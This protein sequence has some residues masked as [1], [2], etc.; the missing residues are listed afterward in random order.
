MAKSKPNRQPKPKRARKPSTPPATKSRGRSP[1]TLAERLISVGLVGV[2]ALA[3]GLHTFDSKMVSQADPSSPALAVPSRQADAETAISEGSS[4]P[5]GGR[6]KPIRAPVLGQA[7]D[8]ATTQLIKDGLK[9]ALD[10]FPK[11]KGTGVALI[12]PSGRVVTGINE[13]VPMMPA[14]TIK[15]AT[16]AALWNT[17]GPDHQ[18]QTKIMVRGDVSGDGVVQ[19]D[20]YLVGDGDPTIMSDL[21]IHW[22]VRPPRPTLSMGDIAEAVHKAGI[23]SVTGSV[24]GVDTIFHGES[25]ATGWKD[26]YL[27]EQ[28]ATHIHA[29]SVDRGLVILPKDVKVGKDADTAKAVYHPAQVGQAEPDSFQTITSPDTR[30]DAAAAL[31]Q[32]LSARGITVG[33]QPGASDALPADAKPVTSVPSPTLRQMVD[34]IELRSDNHMADMLVR[35]LDVH[36][37]G[38]GSFHAGGAQ[39][40]EHLEH[41]GLDTADMVMEDG[42]GLSRDDRITPAQLAKVVLYMGYTDPDW[43]GSLAVMGET[44]TTSNRLKNTPARGRWHGK[45]GSLDDVVSYVGAIKDRQNNVWTLA[46]VANTKEGVRNIEPIHDALLVA[47]AELL[48]PPPS[49][50]ASEG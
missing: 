49:F 43:L 18:F 14:S 39:V 28:N 13:E 11:G 22:K 31:T 32:S 10:A 23:K 3:I 27:G 26:S 15:V 40:I 45:T 8:A 9:S 41:L 25:T 36:L 46:M 24:V 4:E 1:Q 16:G 50:S 5:A 34:W 7:P 21:A 44:G 6:A 38:D 35:R 20:L 17:F 37:G 33:G 19:G 29:L 12:D 30:V 2:V 47:I 42:S 48:V